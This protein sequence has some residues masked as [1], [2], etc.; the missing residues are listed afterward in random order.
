LGGALGE[1]GH[2]EF[3]AQLMRMFLPFSRSGQH[4]GST[5][6]KKRGWAKEKGRTR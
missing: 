1:A 3:L 5:R 2:G 4:C 6:K